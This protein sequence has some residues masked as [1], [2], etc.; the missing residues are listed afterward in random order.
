MPDQ[1]ASALQGR[2]EVIVR[3]AFAR[4]D[5]VALAVAAGTL[6][7]AVLFAATASLLVRGAPPGLQ[8]GPHLGLLAHYL[9]GYKVTWAGSL[10]GVAYGFAIGFC[11]GAAV[12][13][14]WNLIHYIY[15][16]A[17]SKAHPFGRTEI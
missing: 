5:T 7:A 12:G 16:L 13:A 11:A 10:I 9:P 8:V 2:A 4:L 14:F 1:S 3:T 6:C 15:L 17:L